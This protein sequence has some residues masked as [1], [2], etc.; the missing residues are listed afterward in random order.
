MR[1][2]DDAGPDNATPE[3]EMASGS[4]SALSG[5]SGS[6]KSPALL[7]TQT[8]EQRAIS[9]Q[10]GDE[11]TQDV[12]ALEAFLPYRLNRVSEIVSRS[13]ARI[14]SEQYGMSRPDWRVIAIIGQF[15]RVTAKTVGERSTMHKTKVSRAV[16]A[17]EKLGFLIRT[18][19]S[20]DM[21]EIFLELTPAG[22]A[23]YDALVPQALAFSSHL[24]NSL[25]AEQHALLENILE[26]LVAS[27]S[28]FK[29]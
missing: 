9:Q 17:L 29:A 15:G 2:D 26:Q 11:Q 14:Y 13:F 23:A 8:E 27:A 6:S 25:P 22:Q 3:R 20:E 4:D 7:T 16:S 21:R 24:M 1:E 28:S 18:P 19:N 5:T 12:L 10:V